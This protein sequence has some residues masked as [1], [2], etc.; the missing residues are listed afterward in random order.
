MFSFD[1]VKVQ[2][3]EMKQAVPLEPMGTNTWRLQ[4]L[5]QEPLFAA[6]VGKGERVHCNI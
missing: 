2:M 5:C 4:L 6:R 1:E 3:H